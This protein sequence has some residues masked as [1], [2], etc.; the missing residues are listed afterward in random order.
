MYNQ[1]ANPNPGYGYGYPQQAQDQ[2]GWTYAKNREQ[3]QNTQ[4]L[5]QEIIETLQRR[6]QHNVLNM[7]YS[8]EDGWT[9]S[10]THK[11]KNGMGSTKVVGVDEDGNPIVD[12]FEF[13]YEAVIS[14][15][16][17]PSN[18]NTS[19]E[20]TEMGVLSTMYYIPK[21]LGEVKSLKIQARKTQDTGT[22]YLF[23]SEIAIGESQRKS[24]IGLFAGGNGSE[25][26]PY[27]ISNETHFNNIKYRNGNSSTN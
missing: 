2:F 7:K 4:P 12:G 9:Q 19:K 23:G 1:Y 15:L 18:P 24:T 25:D 6:N 10:C 14:Y 17:D 27:I 3:A 5:S 21:R 11:Y 26:E 16:R 13:Y 8:Q 22:V 20:D